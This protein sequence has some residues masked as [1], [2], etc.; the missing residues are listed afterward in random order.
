MIALVEQRKLRVTAND[1]KL[2][3][4]EPAAAIQRHAC[5]RCGVHMFGG[6]ENKAHP[7]Y[8]WDFL[9]TELSKESGWST[10]GFAAFVSSIIEQGTR[11][12]MM[13]AIRA[14]LRELGLEPC[15][16]L[17][18]QLM[19]LIATHVATASGSLAHA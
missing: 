8:G 7:F 14:R 17:S 5:R 16:A 6:I 18:P 3:V 2:T 12:E 1:H 10:P 4:V 19:D 15:D 9:H 13:D 11:P